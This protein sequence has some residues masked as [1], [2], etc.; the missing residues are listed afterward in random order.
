[1]VEFTVEDYKTM[2]YSST[3]M[4]QLGSKPMIIVNSKCY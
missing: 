4:S 3:N 1:M 2:N